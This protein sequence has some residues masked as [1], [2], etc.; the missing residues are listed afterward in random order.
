MR[1]IL[2]LASLLLL[3]F[4]A[5]SPDQVEHLSNTKE[6]AL[7]APNWEVKRIMPKDLLRA[8][9]WAGDSLTRTAERELRQVL[10]DKLAAG[11]VAAAL[12]FCRPT[13]LPRTDSL[14]KTLQATL[15]RVSSR[16]RNPANQAQ[17]TAAELNPADTARQVARPSQE[18]F[19]YQRPLVL[20]DQLC[21]RCH[22]EVGQDIAAADYALIK[23]QY[24]Q[25][26][27][28]GYQLGQVMGAWRVS[29]SR[30]GAAELWTM[31]TRKIM[32]PRKPLF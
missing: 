4:P 11:G 22:G 1:P 16:P 8:T 17:L 6:L 3:L 24:P 26:Q 13:Q 25:D 12:P 31:K 27:A 21:L 19:T 28:T 32:K 30:S 14:A 7:E 20:N 18:V 9:A 15:S 5:C 29:L 2:P 10:A 23:Q